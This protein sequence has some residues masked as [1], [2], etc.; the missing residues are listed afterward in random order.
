MTQR[1]ML[2]EGSMSLSHGPEE[3][4]GRGGGGAQDRLATD[5]SPGTPRR[6]EEQKVRGRFGKERTHL[7]AHGHRL[8]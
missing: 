3:R 6:T 2:D 7:F 4:P 1:G 8:Y 5:G